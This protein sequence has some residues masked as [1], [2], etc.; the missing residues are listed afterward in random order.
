[1]PHFP[2]PWWRSER[3]AWFVQVDGK[4]VN[5]GPDKDAAFD[6]YHELMRRPKKVRAASGSVLAVV[7]AFLDWCEKHR[8]EDTYLWY[9][10]RLQVF[11]EHIPSHLACSGLKP[12]HVLEWVDAMEGV[13]DGTKRNYCRSVQRA[14]RWAEQQ[15]YIDRSPIAH[16][17]KPK[18]GKRDDFATQAEFDAMLEKVRDREF[19][20]LLITTWETGCRPQES[21]RVEARHVDLENRRWVLP[22]A[23]SKGKQIARVVYLSDKAFA[24]TQRL[25]LKYP[26]GKL[27]RNTRGKAW[28]TDAVN[29]RFATLKKKLGKRYCLYLLRHAWAT[30]ALERGLDSLTVAVLLGH[31][32]PSTLARVYQHL[33]QN[34]LYLQEAVKRASA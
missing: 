29:C 2:K 14:M 9:K 5:L 3:N 33:A 6:R 4:Q 21:L 27:F 23:E 26:Q 16:L 32:D 1:M 7:D 30:R 10:Q 11:A 22:P 8:A 17:E 19:R 13:T 34:P 25:A 28:T 12:F 18:A 31:S 15:G 24:I 20:E